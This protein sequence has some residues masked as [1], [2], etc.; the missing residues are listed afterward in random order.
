MADD[1]PG[2]SPEAMRA[3]REAEG[4]PPPSRRFQ[5]KMDDQARTNAALGEPGAARDAYREVTSMPR[6][7]FEAEFADVLNANA[8]DEDEGA[9][10]G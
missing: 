5:E 4:L 7:Q 10:A 1:Y 9:D 8:N 6:D 2:F 3:I